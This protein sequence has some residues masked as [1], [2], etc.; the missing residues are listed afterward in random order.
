MRRN[1]KVVATAEPDFADEEGSNSRGGLDLEEEDS[2]RGLLVAVNKHV[3]N[4]DDDDEEEEAE[5]EKCKLLLEQ[6]S[7]CSPERNKIAQVMIVPA[8]LQILG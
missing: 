6:N 2:G 3:I 7:L 4:E 8:V 1:K 5:N